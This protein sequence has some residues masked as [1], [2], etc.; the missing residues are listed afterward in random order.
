M[1]N[2]KQI[3][4]LLF[5]YHR[6]LGLFLGILIAIAGLTGSAMIILSDTRE[7]FTIRQIEVITPEAARLSLDALVDRA[8]VAYQ[9]DSQIERIKIS[10]TMFPNH[11]SRSPTLVTFIS[12]NDDLERSIMV[13]PYTGK[14][15]GEA[16]KHYF[17]QAMWDLH[18]NLF[19]GAVGTAIMGI[20]ALLGSVLAIT[21]VALWSGWRKLSNGFKIKWNA[22]QK[23]L[24]FDLHKVAGILASVFLLM[25]LFTGFIFNFGDWTVP[26][27]YSI[28]S[29]KP[30]VYPS[31]KPIV[32][33]TQSAIAL[34]LEKAEAAMPG[35]KIE[36]IEFSLKPEGTFDVSK[37]F[38]GDISWSRYIMLDR[39]SGEVLDYENPP[40][41][42]SNVTPDP[43]GMEVQK[44]LVP[45]HFGT[46]TGWSSRFIYFCV[47]LTPTILLITGF[48][49]YRLRRRPKLQTQSDRQLIKH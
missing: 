11:A 48:T 32:G 30:P 33:Q 21:G 4:D 19:A 6:Y 37:K 8:K 45:I 7:F 49:M 38:P 3:R 24:N 34:L 44:M 39:Y 46:W 40:L 9:G 16:P 12:G 27:I 2:A 43:R 47:G 36:Y 31:S 41:N 5:Q 23:R 42:L 14:I 22:H 15:L 35:G 26:V 1:K 10:P 18:T 17:Y 28:T 25:T 13:N 29:S 20:T